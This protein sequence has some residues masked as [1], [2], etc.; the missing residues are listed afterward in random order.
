MSITGFNGSSRFVRTGLRAGTL[1]IA[2]AMALNATALALEGE[3]VRMAR[4]LTGGV[5]REAFGFSDDIDFAEAQVREHPEDPEA[6]FLMAVAYSR[7]PYVERA[8]EALEKSKRLARKHPEGFGVFDRKIAEYE[9]MRGTRPDD[10]AL[11]YRLAFG[12]YMRGYA[13]AHRYIKQDPQPP[14]FYYDRAEAGFRHLLAVDPAD[15]SAMNYLGYLLAERDPENNLQAAESLWRQ[16]LAVTEQNPGAYMLLGQAA[17]KRGD[18]REALQASAKAL[19]AR[20]AWLQA[21][22]ISPATVRVRL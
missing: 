18:L 14:A 16:S 7:T 17:M 19:K 15:F 11:L 13:V 8:L 20:N 5:S 10:P 6:W 4:P 1:A 9:A 12:Y 21:R 3:K 2:A 22:N